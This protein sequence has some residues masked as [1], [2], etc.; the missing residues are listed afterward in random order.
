MSVFDQ[1]R[2]F[3]SL[4]QACG[5]FPYTIEENLTTKKFAKF[6]FSF[7]H[8]ITWWF[9]M[10]IS[11]Q[12]TVSVGIIYSS[13]EQ[14]GN[15][16]SDQNMPITATILF[17]VNWPFYILQMFTTRWIVFHYRRLRNVVNTVQEVERLF[18]EEFVV[19]H[20]SSI[21]KIF[22][23]SFIFIVTIGIGV[24]VVMVPVYSSFSVADM[25]WMFVA[26]FLSIVALNSVM[27]DSTFLLIH[28][29]YYIIG[30][31]M[32]LVLWEPIENS[33]EFNRTPS[34]RTRRMQ[35]LKQNVLI[36]DYLCR[37]TSELN[38]IFAF[39]VFYIVT[40]KFIFVVSMAYAQIQIIIHPNVVLGNYWLMFPFQFVVD[41][42]RILVVLTAADIPAKQVNLLHERVIVTSCSGFYQTLD[43]NISVATILMQIDENRVRLSAFGLF[44]V[45]THLIP[46]LM[47]AAV[48]YLV[49]LIQN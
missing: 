6:S 23:I 43:E 10:V 30:H 5:M 35:W 48:T 25:N 45:G 36:F 29:S 21:T 15:L 37:A 27:F 28:L 7:R 20:K 33:G 31:Y 22:I 38:D 44:N 18:G 4:C 32:R 1:L 2:P 39:P 12:V 14:I 3:V 46:A 47:G 41:W 16:T 42:A 9:L 17:A 49:I 24:L 19:R 34:E 8:A 26:A 11:L 13:M 40:T